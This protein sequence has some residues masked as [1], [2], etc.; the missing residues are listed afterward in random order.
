MKAITQDG[1]KEVSED[2]EPMSISD[3]NGATMTWESPDGTT[4]SVEFE[5]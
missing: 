4:N 5:K 1:F 2:T 3:L